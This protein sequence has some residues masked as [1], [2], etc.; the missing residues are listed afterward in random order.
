MWSYCSLLGCAVEAASSAPKLGGQPALHR[1]NWRANSDKRQLYSS[2]DG[3]QL[4][5]AERLSVKG[6]MTK[7]TQA[8]SGIA[9]N[10]QNGCLGLWSH[11]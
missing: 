5:E 8:D 6:K 1:E 9:L 2:A 10:E 3:W 11:P 7:S 4:Q